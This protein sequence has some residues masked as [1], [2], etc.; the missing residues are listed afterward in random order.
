MF[1]LAGSAGRWIR[2]KHWAGLVVAAALAWQATE[3]VR[4]FPD[5]LAYFNALVGGPTQ[6]H[7]HLVDSSLD[8]GQDLPAVARWIAEQNSA[9][10]PPEQVFLQYLGVDS[11]ARFG[12]EATPLREYIDEHVS[13]D[14]PFPLTPGVYLVSA[15]TVA[16]PNELIPRWTVEYESEY[17]SIVQNLSIL[18][19]PPPEVRMRVDAPAV[20]RRLKLL[21]YERLLAYLRRRGPDESIGYSILVYRLSLQDLQRAFGGSLLED[22]PSDL[23]R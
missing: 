17:Q 7:R 8:W 11:P 14:S 18:R 6:G 4:I 9:A 21:E 13:M 15:T 16:G 12:V 19:S 10:R 1:I 22:P 5:H 2:R 20:L 23:K 3:A